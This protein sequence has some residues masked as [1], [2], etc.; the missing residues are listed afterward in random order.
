MRIAFRTDA[1]P[2][3]GNGH[4][5]RC[6][7]IADALA[8][9]GIDA[10]FF[11][12]R[13][14]KDVERR[15]HAHGHL[16]HWLPATVPD[17]PEP[18]TRL[19]HSSWLPVDAAE[20]GSDTA[21]ALALS[22]GADAIVVDHYAL[23]HMW[24]TELAATGVP[25]IVIDDLADRAHR[26][27]VLIDTNFYADLERRYD[28]LV[29]PDT[30]LCLGPRFALL[31]PEFARL[32]HAL[33]PPSP[34]EDRLFVSL[35]GADL[36]NVTGLV[37]VSLESVSV[38]DQIDVV[39]GSAHP[40]KHSLARRCARHGWRLHVDTIEFASLLARASLAVGAGGTT[41]W[42]RMCLGVPTLALSLASNQTRMLADA[43]TACLLHFHNMPVEPCELATAI[44]TLRKDKA[45]RMRYTR[46]GQALV[47]GRG[48]ERIAETIIT[49]AMETA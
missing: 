5:F 18:N 38:F 35:G 34:V 3:M 39:I 28:G 49:T 12:R 2:E 41:T 14:T 29:P 46:C 45:R 27:R 10:V 43:D 22:G 32:R 13:L 16:L 20:D 21:R 6:L 25:V 26:C 24:E 33:P 48:R 4:G 11:A 44:S 30:V 9:R 47:D 1:A 42:E 15:I 40:A 31:R 36:D 7:T 8:Q 23:D 17:S 19:A 37:L